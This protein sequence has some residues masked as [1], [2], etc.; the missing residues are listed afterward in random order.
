M[1]F[2]YQY[3]SQAR[4]LSEIKDDFNIGTAEIMFCG[5]NTQQDCSSDLP[6]HI[7]FARVLLPVGFFSQNILNIPAD[8]FHFLNLVF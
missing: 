5:S 8:L 2:D 1:L 4:L 3:I 7:L 6:F